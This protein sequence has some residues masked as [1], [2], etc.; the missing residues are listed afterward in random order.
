[1]IK[2]EKT[3][4]LIVTTTDIETDLF[5]KEMKKYNAN[6]EKIDI[7]GI[8]IN[9]GLFGKFFVSHV[10]LPQQGTIGS[11]NVSIFMTKLFAKISVKFAILIGT[12]FGRNPNT[13]KV[14]D[15]LISKDIYSYSTN[16]SSEY[17][18]S[19]SSWEKTNPNLQ[20]ILKEYTVRKGEFKVEFGTFVCSPYVVTNPDDRK[21]LCESTKPYAIGGDME[22]FGFAEACEGNNIHYWA[23]IKGVSDFACP[24]IKGQDRSIAIKNVL[25]VLSNILNN[26]SDIHRILGDMQSKELDKLLP[27][28]LE[29]IRYG[30][31]NHEIL[32]NDH[33][34]IIEW[35]IGKFIPRKEIV[36]CVEKIIN[37]KNVINITGLSL[38][39]KTTLANIV[40][41]NYSC[42]LYYS[43]KNFN[44]DMLIN[45][46]KSLYFNISKLKEHLIIFDDVEYYRSNS[47]VRC[48]VDKFLSVL[49]EN[50]V[51]VIF[52]SNKELP[53]LFDCCFEITK[54]TNNDVI[55]FLEKYNAPH[56]FFSNNIVSFILGTC[57]FE[58]SKLELLIK[59]MSSY[60][61]DFSNEIITNI[62][63][64][65]YCKKFNDEI[66]L[67]LF[68]ELDVGCK[69]LL[70]RLSFSITPLSFKTIS[71]IAKIQPEIYDVNE[72]IVA[73]KNVWIS[74]RVDGRYEVSHFINSAVK[75]N[76]DINMGYKINEILA[77]S[78]LDNKV[79]TPNDVEAAFV[80]LIGA[81]DND[82]AARL[83]ILYLS[84]LM[85]TEEKKDPSF[86]NSIWK[87]VVL[88][89]DING[90]LKLGI[91]TAQLSYYS[92]NDIECA[93]TVKLTCDLIKTE[94]FP[95]IFV[96]PI[97]GLMLKHY[98]LDAYNIILHIIKS[99]TKEKSNYISE[100]KVLEEEFDKLGNKLTLE[101]LFIMGTLGSNFNLIFR[102]WINIM[103]KLD[104]EEIES[105]LTCDVS[106]G[107][108][109]AKELYVHAIDKQWIYLKKDK[110][111]AKI[112][113][114]LDI[115]ND[116]IDFAKR[117]DNEFLLRVSLKV[118][119]V[120][121]S[122]Y[123]DNRDV[124]IKKIQS[125]LNCFKNVEEKNELIS[126]IAQQYWASKNYEQVISWFEQYT[127]ND[128]SDSQISDSLWCLLM[129]SDS[130]YNLKSNLSTK[131]IYDAYK[132]VKRVKLADNLKIIFY[133]EI[134]IRAYYD[135]IVLEFS[136]LYNE[137]CEKIVNDDLLDEHYN[138]IRMFLHCLNYIFADVISNAKIDSP[139][140][141]VPYTRIML[142]DLNGIQ[143]LEKMD[144]IY[145]LL[146]LGIDLNIK[147]NNANYVVLF[148]NYFHKFFSSNPGLYFLFDDVPERYLLVNH[149][150]D[151]A[152]NICLRRLFSIKP[153]SKIISQ[154]NLDISVIKS[155]K[156]YECNEENTNLLFSNFGSFIICYSIAYSHNG[157]DI[158][159]LISAIFEN[160]FETKERSH[161]IYILQQLHLKNY[162]AILEYV[163][164]YDY[165]WLY[166]VNNFIIACGFVGTDVFQAQLGCICELLNTYNKFDINIYNDIFNLFIAVF[167]NNISKQLCL[168]FDEKQ[169]LNAIEK[170][171]NERT[172]KNMKNIYIE[173]YK[174]VGFNTI[175][176]NLV[177]WLKRD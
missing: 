91:R 146:K 156:G 50:S 39:G 98:S 63:N 161:F 145:Q 69:E 150:Y 42:Q 85:S 46:F 37:V 113:E 35:D 173:L 148:A 104:K 164:K 15:V 112:T 114:L 141:I 142:T 71:Q 105:I 41:A 20:L 166:F 93:K 3:D 65:D 2:E 117:I 29:N 139:N 151:L 57:N 26:E 131:Y 33:A 155:I 78:I 4:I 97:I 167:K 138:L 169:I 103:L 96:L 121:E 119:L 172:L 124:A 153:I 79:L 135:G 73:L 107:E 19:S 61:W 44:K 83:Y 118:V 163:S 10:Q 86:I 116:L 40:A 147:I 59:Y 49:K 1:M 106:P 12:A 128:V 70:Y 81:N 25:I 23:V 17:I 51:F 31:E 77:N 129:L 32:C 159:K 127:L 125:E 64:G 152:L 174:Q 111:K 177:L 109:T 6:I 168:L 102:D 11:N 72:K 84:K 175:D 75:G 122:E 68:E 9:Q 47:L 66:Q 58:I 43:L 170:Y 53:N 165:S 14:G 52:V 89:G 171:Y 82:S 99:R 140:Y 157:Y 48:A 95:E 144:L 101:N 22:S 137:L 92:F 88:P 5:I 30:T 13:Q 27:A 176:N 56:Q 130:Y 62:I 45:F 90:I 100:K 154:N 55:E 21:L 7:D 123:L 136:D 162:N 36:S 18:L 132:F 24:P 126:S 115:H 108:F 158:D 94:D 60:D 54:V 38:S 8:K 76:V 160:T 110:D 74:E 120:L 134:M 143:D 16:L 80:Y 28:S 133:S 149:E 87:D 34:N 67:K